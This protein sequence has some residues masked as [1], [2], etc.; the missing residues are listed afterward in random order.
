MRLRHILKQRASRIPVLRLVAAGGICFAGMLSAQA[1]TA[2]NAGERLSA[3]RTKAASLEERLKNLSYRETDLFH[4][5]PEALDAA[6]EERGAL[7]QEDPE[8]TAMREEAEA[9]KQRIEDALADSEALKTHRD[10]IENYMEQIDRLTAEVKNADAVLVVSENLK[11]ESDPEEVQRIS[12]K[13]DV[14]I[15]RIRILRR[16]LTDERK[17]LEQNRLKVMKSDRRIRKLWLAYQEKTHLLDHKV[18]MSDLVQSASKKHEQLREELRRVQ[19]ERD[20]VADQLRKMK[21]EIKQLA[22]AKAIENV[23]ITP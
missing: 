1:S 8:L 2:S 10:N 11:A 21:E 14:L 4:E 19:A 9:L 12:K 17:T 15:E 20:E 22:N 5:I 3:L 6:R 18:R 16:L 13:T 7:K 23:A